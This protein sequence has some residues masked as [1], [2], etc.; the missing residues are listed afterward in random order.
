M[1]KFIIMGL[2]LFAFALVGCKKDSA[3]DSGTTDGNAGDG[4]TPAVVYTITNTIAAAVTV[5]SGE[6][7]V[8]VEANKCVSVK[9]D[10]WAALKVDGVC[11]NSD[12]AAEGDDDA[13]K[14]AK[15]DNDCP[16]AGNYNVAAKTGE[17]ATGNELTADAEAGTECA[18]LK[19]AEPAATTGGDTTGG[20]TTGGDTT[21][22]DTTGE[23]TT[24][25]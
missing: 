6:A 1:K 3:D 9:A 16:A 13:A 4:E 25:N 12:K 8:S 20:D 14:Q 7:S 19:K 22:G 15:K 18:E 5:S 11:D 21:G 17:G 24:G 10:Q 2:T 23:T